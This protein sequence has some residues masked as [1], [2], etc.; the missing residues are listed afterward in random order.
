[1]ISQATIEQI[2]EATDI[3]QLV[4]EFVRLKKRG[5][6]QW[7][8]CPFHT[9]KT[10]SFKVSPDR[11]MFYCFGCSK[12]GNAFTFLME[13]EKMSFIEAVR[14][15]AQ[16][17]NIAIKEDE[18]DFR[19]EEHDR[20][21]YAHEIAVDYFHKLLFSSKY[22]NIVDDYLDE[23]RNISPET[24]RF[25]AMGL[26]D[27]KWDGLIQYAAKK[28]LKPDELLQAGLISKSESKNRYYDRFR[29]RLMIPIYNLSGQPIAFGGRTLKKGELAKYINSPETPLYSKSNTL[30]GLN[31]ARDY[32]RKSNRVIVVEGYFDFIQLWQVGVRNI[33]ASSGTA[34]T[35][36]Q[37]R[38]L[39]RFASE[40]YLFFDADSAGRQAALRSVDHLYEAGLEVK[41]VQAPPGED[42][43]SLARTYGAER[44]EEVVDSALSFIPFRLQDVENETTGI[45]GRE[46]LVKEM[47]TLASRISD[48]TRR[49]IFIQEAAESLAVSTDLF[50]DALKPVKRDQPTQAKK[51]PR[52][53]D[54]YEFELVSLLLH[55]PAGLDRAVESIG[56]D[57]FQST[58]LA[59]MYDA[60]ATA[61]SENGTINPHLM[62]NRFASDPAMASLVSE[63]ADEDWQE[64]E[65]DAE[66]MAAIARFK[67]ERLSKRKRQQL[68]QEL[69]EAEARQDKNRAEEITAELDQLHL[70]DA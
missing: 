49:A 42:P 37:A 21:K 24:A 41:V 36:Q 59:R 55:S 65:I 57:D 66:V 69:A 53:R 28:D 20:L 5:R 9:E 15:L 33:V 70:K 25:F 16:K 6:D 4:G 60:I 13:H 48:Q 50:K 63:L 62:M 58:E 32:I 43:D 18:S 29:Q 23:K 10:P 44:I 67:D 35:A 22:R 46:K 12:G 8:L 34:F 52:R 45:V 27:E 11:Q 3:V 30:Y 38:L 56:R 47:A 1:M 17:A 51:S 19:R 26:S 61:Y 64:S 14:Y 40:A 2:R 31:F 68:L 39:A 54:A 7:G